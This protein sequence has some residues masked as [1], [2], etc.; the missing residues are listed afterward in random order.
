LA[1]AHGLVSPALFIIVGGILYSR[2]H[3]RIINYYRGL[4]TYMPLM[5]LYFFLFTLANCAVP[6]TINFIGEF[7]SLS[8]AFNVNVFMT[9]FASTG[10]ILS[11]AYSV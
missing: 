1:L 11:A 6:L 4:I 3:T 2:Y 10:I 9:F 8:G 5:S 7:L